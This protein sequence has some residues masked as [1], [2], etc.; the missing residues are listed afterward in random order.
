MSLSLLANNEYRWTDKG[1]NQLNARPSHPLGPLM[2][3][4]DYGAVLPKMTEERPRMWP[5]SDFRWAALEHRGEAST[6]GRCFL[7]VSRTTT[8]PRS[9]LSRIPISTQ[10]EEVQVG[11]FAAS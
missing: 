7:E 10:T 2:S 11:Q 3:D 5:G 1:R 9:S 6:L 8:M 4:D